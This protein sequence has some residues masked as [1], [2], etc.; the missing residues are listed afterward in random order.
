M[1]T[2]W[3]TIV[4]RGRLVVQVTD[5]SEVQSQAVAH[6]VSQKNAAAH[7]KTLARVAAARNYKAALKMMDRIGA[8]LTCYEDMD[9]VRCF[10]ARVQMDHDAGIM[11]RP[12][13]SDLMEG[14]KL[15]RF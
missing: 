2:T 13:A 9:L 4:K 6:K 11:S 7:A 15:R 10:A 3:A 5:P 14:T 12:L 8:Q 1:A